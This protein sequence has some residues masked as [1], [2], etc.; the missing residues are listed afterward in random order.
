MLQQPDYSNLAS[1]FVEHVSSALWF[2]LIITTLQGTS[3]LPLAISC[4]FLSGSTLYFLIAFSYIL[5]DWLGLVNCD[6]LFEYSTQ[7][8]SNPDTM[9]W[10]DWFSR[11][12][13]ERFNSPH[14]HC[15][16][17]GFLGIL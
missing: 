7:I 12:P 11:G 10:L 9:G 15:H 6:I 1:Y 3:S 13:K 8:I 2:R 5:W 16:L 17:L 4:W 14:L